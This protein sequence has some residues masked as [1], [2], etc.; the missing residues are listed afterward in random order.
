[1][2]L[3]V[4]FIGTVFA[5]L[6]TAYL[7]PG[8]HVESLYAAIIVALVLGVINITLKP[9]VLLIALPLEILTLGLF[10]FIVNAAFLLLISTFVKGFAIAGFVPALWGALL[11]AVVLWVLD[12]FF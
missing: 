11:I 12:R 5:L 7:I 6:A 3:L 2:S 4:R 8:F 10:T 1:M 9:L